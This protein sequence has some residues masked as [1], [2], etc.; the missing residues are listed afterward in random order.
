MEVPIK[1]PFHE[2][3]SGPTSLLNR[4]S[5]TRRTFGLTNQESQRNMPVPRRHSRS[6]MCVSTKMRVPS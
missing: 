1:P 3:F 2:P 4:M 6:S 5:S